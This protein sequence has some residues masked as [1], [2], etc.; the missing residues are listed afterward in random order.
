MW[1]FRTRRGRS[2]E[3]HAAGTATSFALLT[4]KPLASADPLVPLSITQPKRS[5]A[6]YVGLLLAGLFVLH[7]LNYLY[8]FV[9]D[10]AIPYV[11][12]QNLLNGRGLQYNSFEGRVEG[13]SDFLHVLAITPILAGVRATHLDKLAVFAINKVWSLLCGAAIV[14]LTLDLLRRIPRIRGPGL[15]VGAS[16]IVFAAPLALWSCSALETATFAFCTTL[17]ARWTIGRPHD[18]TVSWRAT[19]CAVVV[20]LTRVDGVVFVI[21]ILGA[22]VLVAEPRRRRDLLSRVVLPAAVVLAAYHLWRVWYFGD[23]L[24]GPVATKILYKLRPEPNLLVKRPPQ[25][26][27]MQFLALYGTLPF[28]G[29]CAL[30]LVGARS[31]LAVASALAAGAMTMYLA[32]VGDWMFGF[33]FFVPV[34]PLFAV[35]V[36]GGGC[37][38]DRFK[39]PL[40]WIAALVAV[41]WFAGCAHAFYGRYRDAQRTESWLFRPSLDPARHFHRYY[42]FLE[43]AR[44][45]VK[46]G[47]RTAYNQAGFLPFMLDLDNIDD[48]GLCSRFFA[49]LPT[50]DLYMTEVGRYEPPTDKPVHKAGEAYLLYREPKFVM[51]PE[52]L[53]RNANDGR[54]PPSL[55]GG[56]YRL[57]FIDAAQRNVLYVRTERSVAPFKTEPRRFL[58]NLAHVTHVIRATLDGQS[59][60]RRDVGR[61]FPWLREQWARVTVNG[62]FEAGVTFARENEAVYEI[63]VDR[64]S[65]NRELNVTLDLFDASGRPVFLHSVE[66]TPGRPTRLRLELPQAVPARRLRLEAAARH[67]EVARL[68]IA[69]VRVLG[70]TPAL[71][72]YIRRRLRF[73]AP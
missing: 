7:S 64:L 51:A 42:S 15:T 71:A 50:T 29:L 32:L 72:E 39:R 31:R 59:V 60:S 47:D 70:Q 23:L 68:T 33:R 36:A 66:L 61:S 2:P 63:Y 45:L 5:A 24:P 16:F 65:A 6:G 52:D 38:I 56:Y 4:N 27:A 9:D 22:A 20:L 48:L 44:Q 35:L 11:F 41:A 14:W 26:Y 1:A 67:G 3:S 69:D 57:G 19:A 10:E 25:N 18:E 17:L 40:G 8:F 21:A 46:P 53:V 54:I 55:Y 43:Q 73:P 30:G 62:Q 28:L 34:L 58:E 13:Y 37:A 49:E 12:A